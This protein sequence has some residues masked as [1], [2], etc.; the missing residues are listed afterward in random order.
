MLVNIF[1]YPRFFVFY[2]LL[3]KN[4]NGKFCFYIDIGR[5]T[6]TNILRDDKRI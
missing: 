3:K 1:T 6:L 2:F 4:E 5:T